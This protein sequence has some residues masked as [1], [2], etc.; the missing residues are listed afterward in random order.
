MNAAQSHPVDLGYTYGLQWLAGVALLVCGVAL[1]IGYSAQQG[2]HA[3]EVK[4]T[5]DFGET[6]VK[7][8]RHKSTGFA[9]Y[10]QPAVHSSIPGPPPDRA[11]GLE[12]KDQPKRTRSPLLELKRHLLLPRWLS[13]YPRMF[14]AL[15]RVAAVGS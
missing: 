9:G 2:A 8:N 7:A 12:R 3:A 13:K 15:A 1:L 5:Y 6:V 11:A 10:L 14:A 4:K